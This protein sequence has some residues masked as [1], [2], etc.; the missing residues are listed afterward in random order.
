MS[1]RHKEVG[2]DP[3]SGP[4]SGDREEGGP[5]THLLRRAKQ[6]EKFGL[7]RHTVSKGIRCEN[8]EKYC[9]ICSSSMDAG[10]SADGAEWTKEEAMAAAGGLWDEA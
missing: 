5:T 4:G 9:F 7:W 2:C 1:H 10:A 3:R 8:L 6:E